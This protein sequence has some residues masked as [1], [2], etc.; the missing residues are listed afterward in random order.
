MKNFLITGARAPVALDLARN[1]HHHGHKVYVADSWRFPIARYSKSVTK[2]LKYRS[3]RFKFFEFKK[4]LITFVKQYNIDYVVPTCEEA[5]YVAQ[6]KPSLSS[7]TNV[8]CDDADLLTSL[9]SKHNVM[10]LAENCNI[11]LPQTELITANNLFTIKQNLS[12][13]VLKKEFSRFGNEVWTEPT[14]ALL[15]TIAI[16]HENY[17]AQE[18]ITGDEICSFSVAHQGQLMS[19]VAY[20]PRY[21]LPN[22]ASYYFDPVNH[23]RIKQFCK[24]IIKKF[25]VTGF[26]SFDFINAKDGTYL[27]EC[28]PRAN[29]GL[30]LL[31]KT[32]FADIIM[33][34]AVKPQLEVSAKMLAYAMKFDALPKALLNRKTGQWKKDYHRGTKVVS[35]KSDRYWFVPQL[36]A[37]TEVLTRALFSRVDIKTITTLDIAFDGVMA[38]E[39]SHA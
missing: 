38:H 14:D 39:S 5:F 20:V 10:N 31:D 6:A 29:S 4:D 36:L 35:T 9:H 13:L 26:I 2:S 7:Y 33:G 22:S 28:N 18:K 23:T 21:R 12:S 24:S 27:I 25:N 1:L 17:I 11:K 30:H 19:H 8:F 32:N 16:K 37:A 34:N 3:P 15:S